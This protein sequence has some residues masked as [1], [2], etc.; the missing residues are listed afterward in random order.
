MAVPEPKPHLEHSDLLEMGWTQLFNSKGGPGERLRQLHRSFF[1]AIPETEPFPSVPTATAHSGLSSVV[2]TLPWHPP[3]IPSGNVTTV[4]PLGVSSLSSSA[5]TFSWATW[6]RNSSAL[7]SQSP[8]ELQLLPWLSRSLFPL[9]LAL[10]PAGC[11]SKQFAL[12]PEVLLTFG[13]SCLQSSLFLTS[14]SHSFPTKL[15][16]QFCSSGWRGCTAQ[17]CCTPF[18]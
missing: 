7:L 10:T 3:V 1:C 6:S 16:K 5:G 12:S 15:Q 18:P 4:V 8:L 17:V 9:Q 2:V 11:I 14:P 13:E